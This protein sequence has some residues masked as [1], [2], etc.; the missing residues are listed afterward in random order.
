VS[1]RGQIVII[2]A[3]LLTATLFLLALVVD[4]GRIAWQRS[5]AKRAAQAAADAGIGIVAENIVTQ[6]VL[7]QTEAASSPCS[8]CTPTP[9]P[10]IA[11]SWLTADD[12]ATLIAPP[13]R[14]QVAAEALEYAQRNG[15]DPA[16]PEVQ[17]VQIDYPLS[18]NPSDDSIRIRVQ[19]TRNFIVLLAGILGQESFDIPV[20]AI[21]QIQ[22]R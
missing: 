12:R 22:Q 14:T 2:V 18:Y 9:D 1:Q 21:S 5:Q 10:A 8:S 7:R 20:E 19:I 6:A 15:F 11:S 17:S 16:Q 4:G 3:V 13:L